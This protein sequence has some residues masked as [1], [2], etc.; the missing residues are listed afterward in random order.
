MQGR[1]INIDHVYFSA[2]V[3]M[4]FDEVLTITRVMPH[5]FVSQHSQYEIFSAM[6]RNMPHDCAKNLFTPDALHC[7][8]ALQC[9]RFGVSKPQQWWIVKIYFYRQSLS[10]NFLGF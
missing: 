9:S 3:L 2:V 6:F 7:H 10:S 1:K 8:V 5:A 4:K